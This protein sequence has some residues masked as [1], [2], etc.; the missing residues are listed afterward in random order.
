[1]AHGILGF[2]QTGQGETG[3]ICIIESHRGQSVTVWADLD[4][5]KEAFKDARADKRFI[6]G[7]IEDERSGE[8]LLAA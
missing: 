6:M 7:H 1:M 8:V 4:D 2:G 3:F 5:A